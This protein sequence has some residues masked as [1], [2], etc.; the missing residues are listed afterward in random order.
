[1]KPHYQ[2][3]G[4]GPP[5]LLLHATLSSSRQ[6]R[7]LATRLA[8]R[9]TVV[10]VDR[11]GSGESIVDGP[12]EPIPVTTHIDDLAEIIRVEGLG[13]VA[14]VGHSYG[15]CIALE[16]ASH[17]PELVTAVFAYEPPYALVATP[18]TQ[19]GM[20]EVGRRTL[21]AY[22]EGGPGAA[23]LT[24]MAGVSGARAVAALSPSARARV[25]RAGQGAVADATLAGM[26]PEALERIGCPVRIATGDASAPFYAEI[27]EALVARVGDADHR[28]LP[29][30]DHMAP[31][32]RPEAIADAIE[33][34]LA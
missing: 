34:F 21:A 10:G 14:A 32:L 3:R 4:D 12:A 30:A 1:M 31:V 25:E 11:R 15:G 17:R 20:S 28:R 8:Q 5:L 18:E 26:D 23:A 7:T 9:Y 22:S 2:R 29:D 6:L 27:A 13:P 16:L 33:D 19:V 24:F